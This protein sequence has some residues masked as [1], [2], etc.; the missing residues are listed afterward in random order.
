MEDPTLEDIRAVL[1]PRFD[2]NQVGK[3]LAAVM[4]SHVMQC[5]CAGGGIGS[6]SSQV[7]NVNRQNSLPRRPWNE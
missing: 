4:P 5:G 2:K 7:S 6:E 3:H 1:N